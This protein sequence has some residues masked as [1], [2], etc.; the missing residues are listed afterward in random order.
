MLSC[1]YVKTYEHNM[2][3][4]RLGNRTRGC[5]RATITIALV[6]YM[7]PMSIGRADS[8]FLHFSP[9]CCLMHSQLFGGFL[10]AE[11]IPS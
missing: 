6:A 7:Q 5:A 8:Q 2:I 3:V 11:V 4:W 9:E 1:L 10:S